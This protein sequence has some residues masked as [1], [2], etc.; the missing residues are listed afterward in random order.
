MILFLSNGFEIFNTD[1]FWIEVC[2][3]VVS[4]KV[5][6]T[7]IMVLRMKKWLSQWKKP[8]KNSG[9][10][11][12][13]NPWSGDY[14]CDALP[15]ELWSHWRWEQ[16]IAPVIASSRVQTPLKS[17]IFLGFFTQLHKLRLLRRSFL[18]FHLFPQFIYD[19][20]HI[21]LTIMV[22]LFISWLQSFHQNLT[23]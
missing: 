1:W 10:E 21:P 7:I 4:T 6:W 12:G 17:W 18:H 2:R 3:N 11:R 16:V 5:K 9:L 23:L 20:F 14:R 22:L 15:T 13:L 19:L 8:E